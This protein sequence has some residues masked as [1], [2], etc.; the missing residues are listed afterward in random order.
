MSNVHRYNR[1][2]NGKVIIWNGETPEEQRP[3]V[4]EEIT[5]PKEL[6]EIAQKW[7]NK[8][9]ETGDVGCCVIGARMEFKYL[10][11]EYKM[12]P[13]SCWQGEGSWTKHLDWVKEELNKLGVEN[14]YYEWG[15]LD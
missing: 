14:I 6:L 3:V 2:Y 4:Q 10:G 1:V 13:Q 8:S 7:Y 12:Y 15:M 9:K 5:V 11:V